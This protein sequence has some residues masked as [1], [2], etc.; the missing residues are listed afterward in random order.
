MN[1]DDCVLSSTGVEADEIMIKLALKWGYMKKEVESNKAKI[2]LAKNNFWG[3]TLAAC[4][5]SNKPDRYLNY[6]PF[7]F[8]CQLIDFNNAEQLEN[9]LK[10]DPNICA[11]MVEPI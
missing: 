10:S 6:G 11:F 8:N 4:G 1:Y 2:I 5:S 9:I 3:R 7:G